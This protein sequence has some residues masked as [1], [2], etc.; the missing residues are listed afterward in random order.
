MVATAVAAGGVRIAVLVGDSS[1]GKTRTCWEAVRALPELWRIWHSLAPSPAE[2]LVE[3]LDQI[4]LR[5]TGLAKAWPRRFAS[6]AVL[7]V[8]ADPTVLRDPIP[9]HAITHTALDI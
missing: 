3:G 9:A 6:A 4:A 7:D 2:A 5:R 8:Y 1:T